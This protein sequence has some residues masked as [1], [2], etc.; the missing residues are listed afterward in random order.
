M[1]PPF[2]GNTV[3]QSDQPQGN[4]MRRPDQGFRQDAARQQQLQNPYSTV[5]INSP[6]PG[7]QFDT[8]FLGNV[9]P[10]MNPNAGLPYGMVSGSYGDTLKAVPIS[11]D[12]AVMNYP[13]QMQMMGIQPGAYGGVNPYY[14][15]FGYR[16]GIPGVPMERGILPGY[17]NEYSLQTPQDKLQQPNQSVATLS[18]QQSSATIPVKQEGIPDIKTDNYQPVSQPVASKPNDSIPDVTST[19][20][21]KDES[22]QANSQ[23]D[24]GDIS[25]DMHLANM[26]LQI[27][28]KTK[29]SLTPSSL[30]PQVNELAMNQLP[31]NRGF[32]QSTPALPKTED[33]R[34]HLD[35]PYDMAYNMMCQYPLQQIPYV[36]GTKQLYTQQYPL[37]QARFQAYPF[38]PAQALPTQLPTQPAQSS[39]SAQSTQPAT[40]HPPIPSPAPLHKLPCSLPVGDYYVFCTVCRH[41]TPIS[42]TNPIPDVFKCAN[43][44]FSCHLDKHL[45][46][47]Y[48]VLL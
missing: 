44:G 42:I 17:R 3:N 46:S 29:E 1:F 15:Y 39:Q 12:R 2:Y 25:D 37:P 6:M 40:T 41:G 33:K 34:P 30:P 19:V 10:V 20:Q 32:S 9:N 7:Q 48:V 5:N 11:Y 26:L 14:P 43:C 23:K 36:A 45:L 35:V 24:S 22:T 8:R 18:K 31:P 4:Q 21:I 28:G 47:Y 16:Q 38:Q 27:K 13:I